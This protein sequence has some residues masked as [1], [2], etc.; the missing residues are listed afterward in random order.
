VSPDP[1]ASSATNP[2]GCATEGPCTNARPELYV[3][4]NAP[5]GGRRTVLVSQ[6][7]LPGQVGEPAPTGPVGVTDPPIAG[8]PLDTTYVYAAPDGSKAF[9]ASKDRLTEAAPVSTEVKE[10]AFN[11]EDG[12]LTYLPGVLGPIVA[13]SHSGSDFIF[14]NTATTPSQL[15]L[16]NEGPNG[17]HVTVIAELP[18]PSNSEAV[19][20]VARG[21]AEGSVFVFDT[22]AP[23]PG[24]F[25]N[26]EGFR[27]IYR[28]NVASNT[29]LC[30]SCLPPG[31]T[32]TGDAMISYDNT[33]GRDAKPRSTVDTRVISSDGNRVFFDTPDPLVPQDTNGKR[34]VYEWEAAGSGSCTASPGCIS[35]ITSGKSSEDSS[36]L[37]N[38]E[39]GNDVFFNTTE[40]L[41]AGDVDGAYDAYDARVPHPGDIQPPQPIPC[42]LEGCRGL[43]L[44]SPPVATPASA[45]LV[46]DGNVIPERVVPV[47]PKPQ[48][49]AA[50]LNRLLRACRQKRNPHVRRGCEAAARRKYGPSRGAKAH[51]SSGEA[52]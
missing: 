17:G 11:L 30:V 18:T 31:R 49:R 51:R 27:E 23:I 40:G 20:V 45:N 5:E 41:V 15:D 32:P 21:S 38:S 24:G 2:S 34:D 22:N 35:L 16:W 14:E 52:R 9:F 50:K 46:G 37:D 3:R 13:S 1:A 36:Y 43:S 39:S 12:T 10:Y 8:S 33:G 48:T 29:T 19:D 42:L 7:Q 44:E 4:E 26:D 47:T 6:S 28:Y 25:N